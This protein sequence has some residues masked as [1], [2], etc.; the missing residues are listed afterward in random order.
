[1]I[2]ICVKDSSIRYRSS[3]DIL[4]LLNDFLAGRREKVILNCQH[5]TRVD[6]KV[7]IPKG[8]I[9]GPLLFL[10]YIND[11]TENLDSSPNLLADD[12]SVFPMVN[13][14]TQFHFQLSSDLAN[15]NN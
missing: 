3:D 11:L 4:S 5:L 2:K 15:I 10:L 13:N 8:S 1:M 6:V 9:L 7:D 14:L 12:I